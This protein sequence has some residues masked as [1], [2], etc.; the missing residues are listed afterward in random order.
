[1]SSESHTE[2]PA[3]RQAPPTGRRILF[4]SGTIIP[5]AGQHRQLMGDVLVEDSIIAAIGP[6]LDVDPADCAVVD[7]SGYFVVPGFVDTHRHLW[8]SLFRLSGADWTIINYRDAMWKTLGPAYTPDDIYLA[9]RIGLA[10]ALDCGVTQVFD[11]NH[12]IITPDHAD[13][14]VQAHDDSL[15]RVVFGYG[16]G[17]P[18]WAAAQDPAIGASVA[19]P[20][21]DLARV[22]KQYYSSDRQRLT[23]AVAARGPE[24]SPMEV[25]RAEADQ[26][27]ELGLRSSIHVGSGPRAK[28]NPVWRMQ[29]IGALSAD[30]TWVHCNSLADS[31]LRLIA[32]S[33][34]TASCSPELELHMGHGRP[35]VGR[36]LALGVRPSLSV[37][38]CVNV[39]GDLFG[40]MRA[41][42]ASVR[43]DAH[44]ASIAA[45]R[46]ARQVALTSGEVFDFATYQGALANGLGDRT[47]SIRPGNQAD[48]V[49]LDRYALNL[50]PSTNPVGT[51]VMGAHPGNVRAVLVAGRVVK[52]AGRLTYPDLADIRARV[53][54]RAAELLAQVGGFPAT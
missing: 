19:L 50:Y 37:D 35:A 29:E 42:L 9:L 38:T 22:S 41:A 15:A 27:R 2:S 45:D 3:A 7:A 52:W 10:D 25:V 46:D 44:L 16:Q 36:L 20:S 11:W 34:G 24:V 23:L 30:I 4:R 53:Q 47:G 49:L 5:G 12:N 54:G 51:I 31:E 40:I 33:G 48:L 6:R 13:A 14:A 32:D 28:V 39:G 43:G 26:A 18:V 17:S 1:M 21:P 8:Q